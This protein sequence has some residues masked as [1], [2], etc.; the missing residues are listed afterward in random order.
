MC[1]IAG[2]FA[3]NGSKIHNENFVKLKDSLTKRGP[4]G[5]GIWSNE[6]DTCG[7]VHTRL[8]ILDL[9]DAGNQ[10][11]IDG[12]NGNVIVFN[13]EI[14]NFRELRKGLISKGVAIISDSDTEVIL[15]LY[16]IY[17]IEC[18][19]FLRGM[20]AFAI[21]DVK[22]KGLFLARDKNGIKPLYY[23]VSS[24]G[25]DFASQVRSLSFLT[26]ENTSISPRGLVSYFLLGHVIE[27]YT[28]YANIKLL[29]AGEILW[30]DQCGMKS[31]GQYVE[32][33]SNDLYK[34]NL[35]LKDVFIDTVRH[36][37]ESDV[38]IG[39]FLSGGADSIALASAANE[40]LSQGEKFNLNHL[41]AF[42]LGFKEYC[43][44]NNDE[45]SHARFFARKLNLNHH[46]Q[47]ME[48]CDYFNLAEKFFKFMDQP[49]VD[50]INTFMISS[51]VKEH[52]LKVALSGLGG[53]EIF[54]GYKSFKQLP[55]ISKAYRKLGFVHGQSVFKSIARS[56]SIINPKVLGYLIYGDTLGGAYLVSRGIFLPWELPEILETTTEEIDMIV[57]EIISEMNNSQREVVSYENKISILESNFYMRNQLLRDADWAGMA[58]SIE[59]RVPFVD[60]KLID[61]VRQSRLSN[62]NFG[63]ND[64][65]NTSS[66]DLSLLKKKSKTGFSVP[67]RS[68]IMKVNNFS[69][70]EDNEIRSWL[71]FTY[72]MYK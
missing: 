17:G 20:F 35:T 43:G 72:N 27:P 18:V 70:F 56:T 10:P 47:I 51:V 25:F 52:N 36:H 49:T 8:S 12:E 53:D 24:G 6:E 33:I 2:T 60:S 3:F 26:N 30:V 59:I 28:I 66:L 48:E 11:M 5:D 23:N 58:N 38:P 54:A 63:K 68:A 34:H 67:V 21:W 44:T 9:T 45:V 13:G 61:F 1:G 62:I 16:A 7:L 37:L 19:Q 22:R 46:F 4:D 39:I 50:G 29:K 71:R 32:K 42:T 41:N 31:L 69:N 57:N 55:I 64:L 15:K 65:L 14:Y 40:V